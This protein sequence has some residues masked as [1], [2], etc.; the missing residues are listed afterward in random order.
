MLEHRCEAQQMC[1]GLDVVIT[2]VLLKVVFVDVVNK[3]GGI[4][5]CE[6]DVGS[7]EVVVDDVGE[8]FGVGD[9]DEK[10]GISSEMDVRSA[11]LFDVI[12][13]IIRGEAPND[14]GPGAAPLVAGSKGRQPLAGS[15]GQ[16]PWLGSSCQ[17]IQQGWLDWI[18][19]QIYLRCSYGQKLYTLR[20][21]GDLVLVVFVYDFIRRFDVNGFR[22]K[23]VDN[24][25]SSKDMMFGEQFHGFEDIH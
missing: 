10:F 9:D 6:V 13:I 4:G 24:V 18:M 21:F 19:V 17:G 23:S 12:V 8:E 22:W 2:D 25:C 5:G 3:E 16:R 11:H 7:V 20:F 15:K 14:G 1:F